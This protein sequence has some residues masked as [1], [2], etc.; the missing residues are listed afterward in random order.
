MIIA[1]DDVIDEVLNTFR[2]NVLFRNFDIKNN[3]DRT[4][5]YLTLHLAQ[6]LTKLERIED[7][8]S[9]QFIEKL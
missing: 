1:E 4:L 7:K 6:C 2:A 3:A 9:G 8:P 5:V